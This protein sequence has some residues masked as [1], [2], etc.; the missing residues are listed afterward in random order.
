MHDGATAQSGGRRLRPPR[1]STDAGAGERGAGRIAA[2]QR[3]SARCR[4][5]G[6]RS[7][8]KLASLVFL[9]LLGLIGIE[10]LLSDTSLITPINPVLLNVM[11]GAGFVLGIPM[12]VLSAFNPER[13]T[14]IVRK[15]ILLFLIPVGTGFAG[16]EAAWRIADWNEFAFSNQAFVAAS[17]PITHADRGRKGRRDSSSRSVRR[18]G[19][20]PYRR[21]PRAV[22]DNLG[23]PRSYCI[24]VLQRR[25]ASGAIEIINDGVFNL[26]APAPATL[27]SC[28][29]AVRALELL[30]AQELERR[31]RLHA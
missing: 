18:Q 31:A 17:Y 8:L 4:A 19:W 25:S 30:R 15:I 27:T 24:N 2:T 5:K 9:A 13:Q 6:A 22:R 16:G 11:R 20:R 1:R 29:E 21:P 14:G 7:A 23:R 10:A 12:A 28:P 26:R 3:A